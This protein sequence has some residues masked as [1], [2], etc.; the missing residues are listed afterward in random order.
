[1][2]KAVESAT[3]CVILALSKTADNPPYDSL[4]V[5]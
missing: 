3:G 5:D 4:S 2:T 1:M